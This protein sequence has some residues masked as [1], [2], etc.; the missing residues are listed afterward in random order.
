MLVTDVPPDCPV[1]MESRAVH[2]G[3]GRGTEVREPQDTRVEQDAK[4]TREAVSLQPQIQRNKRDK[5][6]SKA[7]EL[8]ER[9]QQGP[10]P[11]LQQSRTSLPTT[12]PVRST[13]IGF[14]DLE[15]DPT[16]GMSPD[17]LEYS[18]Q[19]RFHSSLPET[20]GDRRQYQIQLQEASI[21]R[22]RSNGEV[23]QS[24]SDISF[25]SAHPMAPTGSIAEF[26]Q[27]SEPPFRQKTGGIGNQP[28]QM[29]QLEV[30]ELVEINKRMAAD[31]EYLQEQIESQESIVSSNSLLT[32]MI[33]DK[34]RLL[35]EMRLESALLKDAV[36]EKASCTL[37]IDGVTYS[38]EQLSKQSE[39]LRRQLK[40]QRSDMKELQDLLKSTENE[41]KALA[42]RMD[43]L[44][45]SL[46]DSDKQ[47]HELKSHQ[48]MKDEA[49]KVIQERLYASFEEEKAL[50]LDDEALKMAKLE[51]RFEMLTEEME[52]LQAKHAKDESKTDSRATPESGPDN[53]SDSESINTVLKERVLALET[54]LMNI[55]EES[56]RKLQE[57][58][59]KAHQ[60]EKIEQ[61]L[62]AASCLLEEQVSALQKELEIVLAS[63]S[64]ENEDECGPLQQ[65]V[66]KDLELALQRERDLLERLEAVSIREL[67]GPPGNNENVESDEEA[68]SSL[69]QIE[70][71]SLAER[72]AKWQEDLFTAQ[73]DKILMEDKL[74]RAGME[75]MAAR[76]QID[77]LEERSSRLPEE[78]N[79]VGQEMEI[80]KELGK[81]QRRLDVHAVEDV[82]NDL[83]G[84]TRDHDLEIV[85]AELLSARF[86]ISDL[87]ANAVTWMEERT[88]LHG[89][90]KQL[91]KELEE[92]RAISVDTQQR[93]FSESK[94]KIAL[95]E[96]ALSAHIDSDKVF[97]T[98]MSQLRDE[99]LRAQS[100]VHHLRAGLS[101]TREDRSRLE[102]QFERVSAELRDVQAELSRAEAR[103]LRF[104][105]D[106]AGYQAERN[107]L[108]SV[109]EKV[110]ADLELA[111]AEISRLQ[112]NLRSHTEDIT[113]RI[114]LAQHQEIESRLK[115][116]VAHVSELKTVIADRDRCALDNE[117]ALE[118]LQA[119]CFRLQ[120]ERDELSLM[121][122]TGTS[123][124]REQDSSEFAD[125]RQKLSRA[126]MGIVKMQQF[127]QEFQNEKKLAIADLQSRIEES[128]AEV[129]QVRSQ[130]AKA[131][132]MLLA[133]EPVLHGA[134]QGLLSSTPSALLEQPV[135][136][137]FHA[138]S[139]VAQP[140][141]T[142]NGQRRQALWEDDTFKGTEKIHHEAVLELES[143]QQQKAELERTLQDLRHRY[144]LSQKEN[145]TLLSQLE[146][147]N[148]TLRAK[149]ERLSP[150]LATEHLERIR[151]QELE[152]VELSRQLKTAQREREFTRQDMRSLKAELTKLKAARS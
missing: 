4:N 11:Y 1:D 129:A 55:Q 68:G 5:L 71:D 149:A 12:P 122:Q 151:E 99:L 87:Q 86:E 76:A 46:H 102:D 79:S 3:N 54:T 84:E 60:S 150:D 73:E 65:A 40:G 63:G 30:D 77:E 110:S 31:L 101:D 35:E 41:K 112:S 47:I 139:M 58:Q 45:R 90:L 62:R 67:E 132:A 17:L 64:K 95:L 125:L 126:E 96:S 91:R 85:R 152:L 114:P 18:S 32:S 25:N 117:V 131:Q 140:V 97:D 21:N 50:Y 82:E 8:R 72:A 43:Q 33:A 92:S 135:Q 16:Y 52:A 14:T 93:V 44:E 20:N 142:E 108:E 23:P 28:S 24:T 121:S 75:L 146:K 133:R 98:Q 124:E 10:D 78:R 115:S 6:L 127:L 137:G 15:A 138:L 144:E 113:E 123:A 27:I 74:L 106:T 39:G 70:F 83:N 19:E 136:S 69:K 7:R 13:H 105:S 147:E 130:L 94:E 42:S 26:A 80:S 56:T 66:S 107:R 51:Y 48:A 38:A 81:Q 34:D 143:L 37:M 145:D 118:E 120:K 128:D 104:Q 89:S 109:I 111:Y 100:E 116:T 119:K 103:D 22:Q 9:R 59:A 61:Q 2:D 49:Y 57:T 36:Q 148:K 53:K 29:D 134:V 88:I 141:L